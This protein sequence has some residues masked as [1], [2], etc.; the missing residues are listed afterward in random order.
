M[1]IFQWLQDMVQS[2]WKDVGGLFRPTD[3]NY[4]KTGVQPFEGEPR[5][6]KEQY[7]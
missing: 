1:K 5:D 3:D 4:P 6:E 7:Y 2:I